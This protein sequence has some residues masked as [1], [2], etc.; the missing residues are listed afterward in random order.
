MCEITV[1]TDLIYVKL[2]KLRN[3]CQ[4]VKIN[5]ANVNDMFLLILSNLIKLLLQIN[6]LKL[7]FVIHSLHDLM[8]DFSNTYLYY[9]LFESLFHQLLFCTIFISK[10][11]KKYKKC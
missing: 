6:I 2:S 4:W 8:R 10:C 1:K 5:H 7:C 3:I 9:H 11:K